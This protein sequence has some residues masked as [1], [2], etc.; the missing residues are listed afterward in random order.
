M[1]VID[2]RPRSRVGR[3]LRVRTIDGRTLDFLPFEKI[4][5]AFN[6]GPDTDD[7]RLR[8]F[9]ADALEI[10]L[11]GTLYLCEDRETLTKIESMRWF[12]NSIGH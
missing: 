10:G 11:L 5:V 7:W 3:F 12:V 2:R 9:I 6:N 8:S 1:R 4:R